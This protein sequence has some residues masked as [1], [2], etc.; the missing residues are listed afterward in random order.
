MRELSPAQCRPRF[1]AVSLKTPVKMQAPSSAG[2]HGHPKSL[3]GRLWTCREASGL[4]RVLRGSHVL[5]PGGGAG[6]GAD[7]MRLSPQRS[8]RA[9]LIPTS[10]CTV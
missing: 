9:P 10:H 1:C 6:G 8:I 7:E 3:M 2:V 4:V 5:S